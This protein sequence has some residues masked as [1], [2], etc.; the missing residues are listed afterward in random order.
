SSPAQVLALW[1]RWPCPLFDPSQQPR[2]ESLHHSNRSPSATEYRIY[3][4]AVMTTM[5]FA[6][7]VDVGQGIPGPLKRE[8]LVDHRT[9]YVGFDQRSDLAQLP[10][11]ARMNRNE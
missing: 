3:C 9:N 1:G 6:R 10:T 4:T 7:P 5:P 2:R 8:N 11:C